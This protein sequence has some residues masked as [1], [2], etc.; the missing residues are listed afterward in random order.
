MGRRL[1]FWRDSIESG[2]LHNLTAVVA[3]HVV[4]REVGLDLPQPDHYFVG[5]LVLRK[6]VVEHSHLL[7]RRRLTTIHGQSWTVSVVREEIVVNCGLQRSCSSSG[8]GAD[9]QTSLIP[10]HQIILK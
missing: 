6:V 2:N 9:P 5:R 8:I 7:I 1:Q 4:L 10:L 3:V